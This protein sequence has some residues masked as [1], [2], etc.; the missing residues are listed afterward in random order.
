MKR[1]NLLV[2]MLLSALLLGSCVGGGDL[3]D[4]RVPQGGQEQPNKPNPDPE[5][6]P[7]PTPGEEE[8]PF[9]ST[10]PT[11]VTADMTTDVIVYINTEGTALDG[12]TGQI[13][14]H[15]GVLTSASATTADWKYV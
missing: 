15:T 14:A 4:N 10:D 2:V 1:L 12:F 9:I 5:P 13:Y 8:Y 11:F 7:T 6:D 3:A